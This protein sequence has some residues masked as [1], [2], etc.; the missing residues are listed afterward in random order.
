VQS[1]GPGGP[2][3]LAILSSLPVGH[4]GCDGRRLPEILRR[5]V[6]SLL[7]KKDVDFTAALVRDRRSPEAV[8]RE[9]VCP[10]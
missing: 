7:V 4:V 5:L 10:G 1:L 6:A 2:E 9:K 8:V 3:G